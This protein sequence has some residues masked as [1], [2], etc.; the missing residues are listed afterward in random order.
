MQKS[1]HMCTIY[2]ASRA[3]HP[4]PLAQQVS[5]FWL[6]RLGMH[7]SLICRQALPVCYYSTGELTPGCFPNDGRSNCLGNRQCEHT[8]WPQHGPR[9]RPGL[10]KHPWDSRPDCLNLCSSLLNVFPHF[11]FTSNSVHSFSFCLLAETA[12]AWLISLRKTIT[13]LIVWKVMDVYKNNQRLL[14]K[15]S[16][17]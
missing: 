9:A 2:T 8:D 3:I 17:E 16:W 10:E 1:N 7:G 14:Q 5:C 12:G 4:F 6:T 15:I 13:Y 11:V